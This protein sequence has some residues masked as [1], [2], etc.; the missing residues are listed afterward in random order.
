MSPFMHHFINIFLCPHSFLVFVSC[1]LMAYSFMCLFLFISFCFLQL[2]S[3][4]KYTCDVKE[5]S[6][7]TRSWWRQWICNVAVFVLN[8]LYAAETFLLYEFFF[9][10]SL[11]SLRR[12]VDSGHSWHMTD[13]PR[14][15][16]RWNREQEQGSTTYSIHIGPLDIY[17]VHI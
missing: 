1:I 11:W 8:D 16:W 17:S 9:F 15:W 13:T 12:D 7:W 2:R 10:G 6:V 14:I 5:E 4:I 3:S